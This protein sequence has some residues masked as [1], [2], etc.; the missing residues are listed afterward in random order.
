MTQLFSS[1]GNHTPVKTQ[2]GSLVEYTQAKHPLKL[3]F[4]FNPSGITRSR[5][6]TVPSGNC[7][8]TRGGYDFSNQSEVAR[9]SQGVTVNAETLSLKIL[10]DAT[11]RMNAGDATACKQGVQPEIDIIRSMVEPKSQTREG[12]RTLAALGQ[13]QK[14]AFSRH[15]FASV[16]IFHWGIH[17]L[18]VFMTQARIDAKAFL[19]N[20]TPYRAE[21]DLTLQVIESNNPFYGRELERQFRS[22]GQLKHPKDSGGPHDI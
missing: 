10:L 18:P 3:V 14:R 11:D 13:G 8:A 9:A 5:S 21:A 1:P 6:I 22:A 16:L 2:P 20:L 12:A 4:E 19:P 7:A 15:V 17:S